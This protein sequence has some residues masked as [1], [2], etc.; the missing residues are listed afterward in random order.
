M[1]EGPD[2]PYGYPC[3]GRDNYPDRVPE[4]TNTALDALEGASRLAGFTYEAN[5]SKKMKISQSIELG[6]R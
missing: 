6:H 4:P 2:L 3:D 5:S 1:S